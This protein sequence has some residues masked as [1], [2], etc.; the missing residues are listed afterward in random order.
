[1]NARD[2]V[3]ATLGVDFL[4]PSKANFGLLLMLAASGLNAPRLL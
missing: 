4:E 3:A 2:D 1:M